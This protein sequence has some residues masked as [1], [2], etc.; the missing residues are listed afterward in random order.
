MSLLSLEIGK[1][2]TV[3]AGRVHLWELSVTAA[4]TPEARLQVA[5]E[6]AMAWL[7]RLLRQRKIVMRRIPPGRRVSGPAPS[8]L[9]QEASHA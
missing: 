3:E 9:R 8:Q 5:A 7:P 4:A 6:L 1:A 2:A